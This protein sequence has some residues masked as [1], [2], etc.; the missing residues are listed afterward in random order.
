MSDETR[1]WSRT[2]LGLVGYAAVGILFLASAVA[3]FRY[4]LVLAR[5]PVDKAA[6]GAASCAVDLL[7]ACLLI[8]AAM[9]WRRQHRLIASASVALWLA[10]VAWSLSSAIGFAFTTRA[11][12][13]V[14]RAHE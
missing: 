4:G 1:S 12:A 5:D 6:Y 3:N 7:K 11:D 10:C 14:G 13:N 2:G 9:L 8:L